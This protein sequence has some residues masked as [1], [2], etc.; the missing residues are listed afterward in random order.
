MSYHHIP[1]MLDEVLGYLNCRPGKIYVDCTLGGCGHTLAILSRIMPEGRLIGLDQDL[2]AIQNAREV[3]RPFKDS[4]RLFHANFIR[5][6]ELL[7]QSDILAVDGILLDLGLSLHQLESSGR[8]FSFFKNEPLDMRM[9]I[10]SSTSA[11][12]LINRM[13]EK[14]LARIFRQYGEERMSRKIARKIIAVRQQAPITT[15]RQLAELICSV[16]PTSGAKHRIHPAT[17]TFMALRI[18]VNKELERLDAFMQAAADL[19]TPGGRLCVLSFHSLEDRIVKHSL[20]NMEK[21]CICPPDFPQ[22]V[23]NKQKTM[24]VLTRRAV[25]PTDAEIRENRMARSTKLR[26]AEKI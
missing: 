20:K 19:L 22:C 17:R 15:S 24:R 5:L 7:A 1:V 9:D 2:D 12:D 14:E 3:L 23:C 13:P 6:P 4:V 16:V 21:A 10:R 18:A 11:G 26:A 25:C 8:G